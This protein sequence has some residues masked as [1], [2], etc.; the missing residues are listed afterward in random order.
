MWGDPWGSAAVL[1]TSRAPRLLAGSVNL[2]PCDDGGEAD[3]R[4]GR[5]VALGRRV[6]ALAV[7]AFSGYLGAVVAFGKGRQSKPNSQPRHALTHFPNIQHFPEG[8]HPPARCLSRAGRISC[9]CPS[10][11]DS[12]CLLLR[13][14]A[15]LE[16]GTTARSTS[17]YMA[18]RLAFPNPDRAA[19]NGIALATRSS[20]SLA[21]S[22]P[23]RPVIRDPW[24]VLL[25]PRQILSLLPD[26]FFP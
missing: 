8:S 1:R 18:P 23:S 16:I 4:L 2:Q 20:E 9:C 11:G 17:Q 3:L 24:K 13:R 6:R 7:L 10:A 21:E 5:A 26:Y 12:V 22:M 19:T 14:Q 25:S 15:T